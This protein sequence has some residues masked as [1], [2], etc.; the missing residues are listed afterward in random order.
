M[1]NTRGPINVWI[2]EG[3]EPESLI[4]NGSHPSAAAESPTVLRVLAN[5]TKVEP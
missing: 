5:P 4:D 2:V 3:I 1:N